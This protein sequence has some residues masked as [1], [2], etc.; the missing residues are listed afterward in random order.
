MRECSKRRVQSCPEASQREGLSP[1]DGPE[2]TE[3]VREHGQEA[4]CLRRLRVE[5]LQRVDVKPLRQ[6]QGTPLACLPSLLRR[7]SF[8]YEGRELRRRH[9]GIFQHAPFWLLSDPGRSGAFMPLG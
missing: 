6:R 9:G 2:R 5:A 7:S 1:L 3:G 4:T 8:G